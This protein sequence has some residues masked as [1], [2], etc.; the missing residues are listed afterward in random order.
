VFVFGTELS[1]SER[2]TSVCCRDLFVRGRDA[3]FRGTRSVVGRD[4][5]LEACNG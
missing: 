2:E 1:V 3:S 5:A 4:G